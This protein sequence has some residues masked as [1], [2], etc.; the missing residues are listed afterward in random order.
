ML[1][2]IYVTNVTELQMLNVKL[3]FF[4]VFSQK[5]INICLVV[6]LKSK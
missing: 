1:Q 2:A 3:N 6:V 5:N 4:P